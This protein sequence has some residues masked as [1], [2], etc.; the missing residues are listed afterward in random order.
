MPHRFLMMDVDGTMVALSV[1]LQ[2]GIATRN[3]FTGEKG[4]WSKGWPDRGRL[5]DLIYN[6]QC[7]VC[8]SNNPCMIAANRQNPS[9]CVTEEGRRIAQWVD[10]LKCNKM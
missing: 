5:A 6:Y 8:S 1:Q 7:E 10:G 4:N 2:Y 9:H 3:P